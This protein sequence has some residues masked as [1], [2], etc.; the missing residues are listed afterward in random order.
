MFSY[1]FD[2]VDSWFGLLANVLTAIGIL[3]LFIWWI[4]RRAV[5]KYTFGFQNFQILITI[6]FTL[7]MVVKVQKL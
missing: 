2:Q 5:K 7:E 1:Y 6:Y 4:N 3:G